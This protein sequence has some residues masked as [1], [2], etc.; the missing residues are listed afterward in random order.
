MSILGCEICALQVDTDVDIETL[1]EVT[2]GTSMCP[3]CARALRYPHPLN[4]D[5]DEQ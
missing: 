5:D 3:D 1:H 4:G 2:P